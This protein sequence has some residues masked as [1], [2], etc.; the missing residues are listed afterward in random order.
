[1]FL[2]IKTIIDRYF[3]LIF[4]QSSVIDESYNGLCYLFYVA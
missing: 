4:L 2:F 3:H 1:M